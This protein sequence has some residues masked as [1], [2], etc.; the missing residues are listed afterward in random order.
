MWASRRG[1]VAL[2][3]VLDLP[4]L[5]AQLEIDAA[6]PRGPQGQIQYVHG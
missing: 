2:Q 1:I 3:F 6:R 4:E 5:Y